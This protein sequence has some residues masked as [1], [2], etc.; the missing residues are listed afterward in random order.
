VLP[1]EGRPNLS[2]LPSGP[3]SHRAAD[4]I[5]PRLAELLDEFAKE[6]DLVILDSPPLL[7]FAECL[8]MASA[9]DGVL[10]ISRAGDTKREAV[11]TVVSTLHRIRANVLGVVLNR[12]TQN[13]SSKEYSYYGY[14][15]YHYSQDPEK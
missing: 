13:T 9:A 1:V 2:L 11:A 15:D 8:Q 6:Y 14:H 7:G 10:I 5:G 4:L 3:G 12:V